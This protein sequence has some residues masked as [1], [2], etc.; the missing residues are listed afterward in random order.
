MN[1]GAVLLA[2]VAAGVLAFPEISPAPLV[3]R[4]GEGWVYESGDAE[5]IEV[6]NSA[7]DQL[8]NAQA[9]EAKGDLG[10]ALAS[11]RVLVRRFPQT[12]E[13]PE[14]QYKVGF[15]NE[16]NGDIDAAFKAYQKLIKDYPR[17]K[18]FEPAVESMFRIATLYLDG[19]KVKLLGIPVMSSMNQ[20][21]QKNEAVIKAAPFGKYAPLSQ[22]NIGQ[23]LERQKK[24]SEAVAAYQAVVEKYPL[25]DI[26]DD[27]QYQIGYAWMQMSSEGLYDQMATARAI[28]AFDDFLFRYPKSEK[29]PQA[30]EN[31][32]FLLGRMKQS[33][34]EI[35]RFYD[36][37]GD[38]R[39]ALIYY[40]AVLDSG[41]DN[42][43]AEL[44]RTR[45]AE[46]EARL[47]PE[48]A[49]VDPIPADAAPVPGATNRKPV[50]PVSQEV[51]SDVRKRP[52]YV[53]PEVK[54]A[55]RSGN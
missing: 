24:Y 35:A 2:A 51:A 37:Q 30:Q 8:A 15:L 33:A 48:E 28:E 9:Y 55:R 7:R 52:D 34:Y 11:Y 5:D 25:N 29:V 23:A 4:P 36:R 26:A 54:P 44:A 31:I 16:Q 18:D 20:A 42:E 39:A 46:L 45:V 10:R 47:T 41:S 13:A 21:V 43:E 19:E 27:A 50:S 49:M 12:M 32:T 6:A 38:A 17:S 14:A 53:G 22:F 3:W 40:N 1:K